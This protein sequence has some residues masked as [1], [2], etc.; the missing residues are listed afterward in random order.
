[1]HRI[2]FRW[3]TICLALLVSVPVSSQLRPRLVVYLHTNIRARALEAALQN[4]MPAIDVVVCSRHRDFERELAHGFDAALAAQPVLAAHG[5]S[6]DMRGTRAGDD[7]EAYI[8]LSIATAVDKSEFASLTVG[9][10]DLL[11]RDKTTSFVARLL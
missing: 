8:L 2:W 6:L 10:V 11:G 7:K 9:A 1:M 3:L 5:L 4:Q